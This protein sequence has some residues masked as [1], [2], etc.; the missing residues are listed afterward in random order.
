MYFW[1]IDVQRMNSLKLLLFTCECV[2]MTCA[3]VDMCV[4][5]GGQGN[6]RG[7]LFLMYG[8]QDLNSGHEIWWQAPL[9]D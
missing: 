8:S 1:G 4:E 2:H 9:P 6:G 7:S 3:M 5:V